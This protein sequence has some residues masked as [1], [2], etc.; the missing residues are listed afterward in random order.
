MIR[1]SDIMLIQFAVEGDLEAFNQLVLDHQDLVYHQ[2]VSILKQ[3]ELAEDMTQEAFILAYRKLGSFRGGSFRAWLLRIVTNVC[4]DELR[5][6]RRR[7]TIPLLPVDGDDEALESP[8]WLA[9]P[10]ATP[11]QEVERKDLRQRLQGYL[12]ELPA[13]YRDLVFLIDIQGLDYPEAAESLR[14]P[15]GTVKSRL[16]RARAR[17]RARILGEGERPAYRLAGSRLNWVS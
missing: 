2:A 7:A 8:A 5:R 12:A 4:Y 9:D 14:I 10:A 15:L 1:M 6:A 11:E 13:E 16:A 17:L 3:P